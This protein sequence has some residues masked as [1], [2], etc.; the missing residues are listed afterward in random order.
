MSAVAAVTT[1]MTGMATVTAMHEHVQEGTGQ[2]QQKRQPAKCVD[3]V[4]AE[5]EEQSNARERQEH[6]HRTRAS[7]APILD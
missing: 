2:E 3:P 4:L 7:S 1:G 5:K 6:E